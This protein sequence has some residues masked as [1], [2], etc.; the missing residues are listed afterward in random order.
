MFNKNCLLTVFSQKFTMF[1]INLYSNL[2][3][4]ILLQQYLN[5]QYSIFHVI[6]YL[7]T[8]SAINFIK[9]Q[10]HDFCIFLLL[11]IELVLDIIKNR[12]KYVSQ[13]LSHQSI[14][15]LN[16]ELHAVLQLLLKLHKLMIHSTLSLL[17]I[18]IFILSLSL[19]ETFCTCK[20]IIDSLHNHL[21]VN[22]FNC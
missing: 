15:H 3:F 9:L 14:W 19:T 5:L 20:N 16:Q 7:C 22:I 6:L 18:N 2:T 13:I 17:Y 12:Y 1:F 10:N 8:S 11:M 4:Y 21:M